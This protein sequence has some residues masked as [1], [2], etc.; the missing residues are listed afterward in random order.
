MVLNLIAIDIMG[1]DDVVNGNRTSN[2]ARQ[3]IYDI[4][5]NRQ[6]KPRIGLN[7]IKGKKIVLHKIIIS[8][9]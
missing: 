7:I 6:D 1:I 5:G 2:N 4:K 8:V 9:W 3:G